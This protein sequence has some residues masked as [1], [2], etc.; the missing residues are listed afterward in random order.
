MG[1][2]EKKD[3][4]LDVVYSAHVK[5]HW[6]LSQSENTQTERMMELKIGTQHENLK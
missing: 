4:Q 6:S 1:E 3:E 2:E 5:T